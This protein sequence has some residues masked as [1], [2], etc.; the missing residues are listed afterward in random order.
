MMSMQMRTSILDQIFIK[1]N[2][3]HIALMRYVKHFKLGEDKDV[4]S[5]IKANAQL[6]QKMGA[7]IKNANQELNITMD[8]LV[9]EDVRNK[10]KEAIADVGEL[11]SS[12]NG[13]IDPDCFYRIQSIITGLVQNI[14][15]EQMENHKSE[16]REFLRNGMEQKYQETIAKFLQT[17]RGLNQ[18][19][20]N[21]Y[22]KEAKIP[23]PL[24][25]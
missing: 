9:N 19:L 14:T 24:Y 21:E 22:I 6:K 4:K 17:Q 11:K 5:I 2:L 13:I 20:T 23:A 12:A 25:N 16:R 10:M 3:K 1:H 15:F 7:T 8:G 18:T